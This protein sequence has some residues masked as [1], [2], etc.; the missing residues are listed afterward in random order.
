MHYSN[1]SLFREILD[2]VRSRNAKTLGV[3]GTPAHVLFE[4][5]H[6]KFEPAQ[7]ADPLAV[8]T[9]FH[10]IDGV[11]RLIL[12]EGTYGEVMDPVYEIASREASN[13]GVRVLFNRR[14]GYDA[15]MYGTLGGDIW[16]VK[17]CET[18]PAL[19]KSPKVLA[20]DGVRAITRECV[21]KIGATFGRYR[22]P[23]WMREVESS[24]AFPR[25]DAL[26]SLDKR[27]GAELTTDLT[28]EAP[29]LRG[30][31]R[32]TRTDADDEL[33]AYAGGSTKGGRVSDVEQTVGHV[34][35]QD[36]TAVMSPGTARGSVG[37][38]TLRWT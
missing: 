15:R 13:P 36:D 7:I 23:S 17:L 28:G 16:P 6:A 10:V 4:L 29:R 27:F 32:T 25:V 22:G 33:E 5:A 11:T 38:C 8:I 9:G 12:I 24:R 37:A 30:V 35:G 18:V 3:D 31:H 34:V 26:V 19:A 1:V 20:G 21:L 2:V 14:L